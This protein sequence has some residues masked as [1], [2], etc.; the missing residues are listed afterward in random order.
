[1]SVCNKIRALMNLTG[2]KTQ[3]VADSLG[4]S[5]QGL[6][7]KLSRDSF[8]A[9]DLIKIS[10]CLGCELSIAMDQNIKITLDLTDL[11]K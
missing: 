2:K 8:S 3:E 1:M 9:E 7:N 11:E 10:A 5:P 4:I 6:R